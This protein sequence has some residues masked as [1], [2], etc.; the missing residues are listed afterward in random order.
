MD[1]DAPNALEFV[2]RVSELTKVRAPRAAS[3]IP[4]DKHAHASCAQW[5]LPSD[6]LPQRLE[7]GEADIAAAVRAAAEATAA[8]EATE[9]AAEAVKARLAERIAESA[10]YAIKVAEFRAVLAQQDAASHPLAAGREARKRML[11]DEAEALETERAAFF[12]R[13]AAFQAAHDPAA[14]A[15]QHA[16]AVAA[17]AAARAELAQLQEQ[18]R[19]L[20]ASTARAAVDGSAAA[21]RNS[22]LAATCAGVLCATPLRLSAHSL[23]CARSASRQRGR[24]AANGGGAGGSAC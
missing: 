4:A 3:C 1:T 8:L 5:S 18:A 23:T 24:R 16:Q 14:F 7:T 15:A 19:E 21:K 2:A 17:A 13:C 9:R 11:A 20:R 12:A 10:K 6:T 22:E